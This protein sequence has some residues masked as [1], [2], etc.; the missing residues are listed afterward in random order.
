M[1]RE[2]IVMPNSPI[3]RVEGYRKSVNVRP[4]DLPGSYTLDESSTLKLTR[5]SV[6]VCNMNKR[7]CKGWR[8]IN[9]ELL[10]CKQRSLVESL[11]LPYK[12]HTILAALLFTIP[13]TAGDFW[14]YSNKAYEH[15]NKGLQISTSKQLK[16]LRVPQP[17]SMLLLPH[18]SPT[19]KQYNKNILEYCILDCDPCWA[20]WELNTKYYQFWDWSNILR[21]FKRYYC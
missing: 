13:A 2:Q 18:H 11:L 20:L 12:P 10:P 14:S 19:R 7:Q 4:F 17:G 6:E 9:L 15:N 5:H 16:D 21:G 1:L 8:T 3:R